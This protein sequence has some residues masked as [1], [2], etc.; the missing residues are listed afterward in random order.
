MTAG[1]DVAVPSPAVCNSFFHRN[2][3]GVYHLVLPVVRIVVRSYET[4]DPRGHGFFGPRP[5]SCRA[6][7]AAELDPIYVW[8]TP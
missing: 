1:Y 7:A 8:D 5:A 6:I 3:I 2:P 4:Q